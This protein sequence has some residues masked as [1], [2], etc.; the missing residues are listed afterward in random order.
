MYVFS[1]QTRFHRHFDDGG[2]LFLVYSI[3]KGVSFT[4]VVNLKLYE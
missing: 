3:N 2:I 4:I 1:F